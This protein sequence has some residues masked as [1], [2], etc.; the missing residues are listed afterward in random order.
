MFSPEIYEQTLDGIARFIG[1]YV[2]EY[3]GDIP[4]DILSAYSIIWSHYYELDEE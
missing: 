2:I 3:G 4:K 1:Y